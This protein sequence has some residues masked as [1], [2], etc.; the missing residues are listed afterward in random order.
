MWE[1]K[2]RL[3]VLNVEKT[4]RGANHRKEGRAGIKAQA[5]ENQGSSGVMRK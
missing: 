4:G 2:M 3:E 1:F 5:L